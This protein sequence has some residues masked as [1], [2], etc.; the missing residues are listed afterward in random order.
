MSAYHERMQIVC[1]HAAAAAWIIPCLTESCG[2]VLTD[3]FKNI[4]TQRNLCSNLCNWSYLKKKP[5]NM[6]TRDDKRWLKLTDHVAKS[7]DLTNM[8]I[9][10]SNSL[11]IQNIS[12]FFYF[13]S[14]FLKLI[15]SW[16][17]LLFGVNV[18]RGHSGLSTYSIL[19]TMQPVIVRPCHGR[20]VDCRLEPTKG[21]Y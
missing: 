10:D 18:R 6:K 5:V 13:L 19:S 21:F 12:L 20:R 16:H 11:W 9:M 2:A 3:T 8:L 1:W 7:Y 14:N 15:F 17:L 4:A